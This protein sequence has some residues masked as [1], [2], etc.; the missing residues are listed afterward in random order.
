MDSE[1]EDELEES[2]KHNVK[3]KGKSKL[4]S[5]QLE[6]WAKKRYMSIR[7]QKKFYFETKKDFI[8]SDNIVEEKIESL[9]KYDDYEQAF[10]LGFFFKLHINTIEII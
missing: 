9:V 6:K 4:I 7:R 1:K 10:T 2:E 8:Y 3:R 5:K